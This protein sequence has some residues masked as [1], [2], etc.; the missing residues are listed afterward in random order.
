MPRDP[1]DDTRGPARPHVLTPNP[2]VYPL[3]PFSVT[4]DPLLSYSLCRAPPAAAPHAPWSFTGTQLE[5][6]ALHACDGARHGVREHHGVQ[7]PHSY[8]T[9]ESPCLRLVKHLAEDHIEKREERGLKPMRGTNLVPSI[10]NMIIGW[11]AANAAGQLMTEMQAG[12]HAVLQSACCG[13]AR[14]FTR[15]AASRKP[16]AARMTSMR[17]ASAST[18]CICWRGWLPRRFSSPPS[19]RTW[20]RLSGATRRGCCHG[21]GPRLTRDR[22]GNA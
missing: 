11:S 16:E 1:S 17:P 13:Q 22:H 8:V 6:G 4:R 10:S 19:S 9:F 21:I 5:V 20:R 18:W 14:G 15:R 3:P 12:G 2:P 7:R